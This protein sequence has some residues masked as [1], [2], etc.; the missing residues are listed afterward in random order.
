VAQRDA[1]APP[2]LMSPRLPLATVCR[3]SLRTATELVLPPRRKAAAAV[4]AALPLI[5]GWQTFSSAAAALVSTLACDVE[6]PLAQR[7]ARRPAKA[8]PLEGAQVQLMILGRPALCRPT[9]DRPP[10]AAGMPHHHSACRRTAGPRRRAGTAARAAPLQTPLRLRRLNAAVCSVRCH[11]LCSARWQLRA[12][13]TSQSS[14]A[15]LAMQRARLQLPLA[16]R[17]S[18]LRLWAAARGRRPFLR[19]RAGPARAWRAPLR[20]PRP[21]AGSNCPF[22]V[23]AAR[24]PA[25][26]PTA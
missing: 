21:T 17:L 19:A 7:A 26:G 24:R 9:A 23:A 5:A 22:T 20:R 10:A 25:F 11:P 6:R 15:R 1:L 3:R 2:A 8:S 12:A 14:R 16:M 13:R 18:V 4:A